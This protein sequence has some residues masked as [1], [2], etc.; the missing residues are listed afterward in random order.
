MGVLPISVIG[1]GNAA[2]S[3][4][5]EA[6]VHSVCLDNLNKPSLIRRYFESVVGYCSDYGTEWLFDEVPPLSWKALC[7]SNIVNSKGL[8]IRKKTRRCGSQLNVVE[9][10][11][12]GPG[13]KDAGAVM[14]IT[15]ED[16]V[17]DDVNI[18]IGNCMKVPGPKHMYDNLTSVLLGKLSYYPHFAETWPETDRAILVYFQ[19]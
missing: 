7:D 12:D 5:F 10:N 13:D 9:D 18:S 15:D 8:L 17:D 2:L 6:L 1:S 19:T 3:A 11:D 4:K 16:D 14:A